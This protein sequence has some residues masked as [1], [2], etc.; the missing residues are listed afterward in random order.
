MIEDFSLMVKLLWQKLEVSRIRLAG[1][2]WLWPKLK[3]NER[4]GGDLRK[5]ICSFILKENK[6]SQTQETSWHYPIAPL[7][8]RSFCFHLGFFQVSRTIKR[9]ISANYPKL[10]R[11]EAFAC[12]SSWKHL[13]TCLTFRQQIVLS[14]AL[15][16]LLKSRQPCCDREWCFWGGAAAVQPVCLRPGAFA[17]WYV[18]QNVHWK[19]KTSK[20][21]LNLEPDESKSSLQLGPWHSWAVYPS[22][23][24]AMEL[25]RQARPGRPHR[26]RNGQQDK[27]T[28][29][30]NS[31]LLMGPYFRPHQRKK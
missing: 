5:I 17:V 27:G 16:P 4:Q 20:S 23:A 12:L 2:F 6:K 14:R 25:L 30:G 11:L 19:W 3:E 13:R 1:G 31:F 26:V 24:R 15:H 28:Q 22:A 29:V 9:Q 10:R 21:D 7:L 18:M 8:T